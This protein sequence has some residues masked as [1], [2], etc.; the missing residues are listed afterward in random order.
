MNELE[1]YKNNEISEVYKD[2]VLSRSYET[3]LWNT[4]ANTRTPDEM[5]KEREGGSGK[6][7]EYIS[8]QYT[9]SELNRLFPGWWCEEM[10]T[11]YI[12]AVQTFITTGYLMIEYTLPNGTKKIRKVYACGSC[13]V[14][15]KRDK[16]V[17]TPSQPDDM[18]KGSRTEWIKLAGKW[19]GIGLD[20]YTQT[21]TED[22]KQ[23][24][25]DNIRGWEEYCIG[26]TI[27]V[28]EKVKTIQTSQIFK[29]FLLSMPQPE[30]TI[31][32][33]SMMTKYQEVL[34]DILTM[35]K[36]RDLFISFIKNSADNALK[37]IDKLETTLLLTKEKRSA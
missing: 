27:E 31:R 29:K 19:L 36:Q 21:I 9:L 33:I 2:E 25:E 37:F 23:K 14:Q 20:I 7:L 12:P 17:P 18:A 6:M 32:F 16:E 5:V 15:I 3:L 11:E 35:S 10:K 8:E 22:L 4:I 13:M 28:C 26:S 1:I 24:F 30:H 34:P